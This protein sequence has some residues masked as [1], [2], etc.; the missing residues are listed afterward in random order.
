MLGGF[1]LSPFFILNSQAALL[2]CHACR[3]PTR[4]GWHRGR[5]LKARQGGRPKPKPRRRRKMSSMVR[6]RGNSRNR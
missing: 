3:M 4:V 2:P 6:E 5:R 1:H